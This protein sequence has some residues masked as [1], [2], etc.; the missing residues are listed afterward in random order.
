M[1][2]EIEGV[3]PRTILR[4]VFLF[5]GATLIGLLISYAT[6]RW[7]IR[8]FRDIQFGLGMI[9][10]GLGVINNYSYDTQLRTN[11]YFLQ[12]SSLVAPGERIPHN[13]REFLLACSKPLIYLISGLLTIG[14]GLGM[15]AMYG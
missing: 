9:L 7:S 5:V 3:I 4:V 1:K 6:G 13:F 10:C 12:R 8:G 14:T 15:C 11:T 2:S